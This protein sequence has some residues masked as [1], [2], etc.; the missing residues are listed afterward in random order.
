MT[1]RPASLRPVPPRLLCC[2]CLFRP[3]RTAAAV[4]VMNGHAVCEPHTGY[5][6]GGDHAQALLTL[7][8]AAS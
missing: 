5:V 7:H 8:R 6:Q 4:T 1:L 3:G 2:L